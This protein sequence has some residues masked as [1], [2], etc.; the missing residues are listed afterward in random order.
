MRTRGWRCAAV[1]MLALAVGA[2][3]VSM[4]PPPDADA[5]W[6]LVPGYPDDAPSA[7][8]EAEGLAF[9]TIQGRRVPVGVR[10]VRV[11]PAEAMTVQFVCTGVRVGGVGRETFGVV[12][13]RTYVLRGGLVQD[14]CIPTLHVLP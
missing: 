4:P 12:A 8:L 1:V 11:P 2:C 5:V 14:G 10:R 3:A 9:S 7:I 13:G 6:T